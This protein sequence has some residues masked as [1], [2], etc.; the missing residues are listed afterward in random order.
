[1]AKKVTI[2]EK[3]RKELRKRIE[4]LTPKYKWYTIARDE[5]ESVEWAFLRIDRVHDV[6][7]VFSDDGVTS[8]IYSTSR[9]NQLMAERTIAWLKENELWVGA[10]LNV[11]ALPEN[12][13]DIDQAVVN[14]TVDI[15]QA[16]DTLEESTEEDKSSKFDEAMD[17][18]RE[19]YGVSV[20]L[21]ACKQLGLSKRTYESEEQED[22]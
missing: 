2:T 20:F 19:H 11:D 21:K 10:K 6:A 8:L 5:R 9:G 3:M 15:D 18:I 13:E 4:E 14:C 12:G 22:D 7:E 16:V 17:N 1:M